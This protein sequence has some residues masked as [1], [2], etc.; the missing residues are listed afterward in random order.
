MSE[1]LKPVIVTVSDE[2]LENIYQVA[3]HLAAEGLNVDQVFPVTGV[4]AGTSV[5]AQMS[6]LEKVDGVMSVEEEAVAYLS[7]IQE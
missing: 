3:N 1:E 6:V 2:Q 4:I 7:V 5:P